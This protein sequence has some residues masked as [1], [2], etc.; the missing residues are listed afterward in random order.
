MNVLIDTQIILH[1]LFDKRRLSKKEK[2]ILL[3][4]D[5]EIFC[6]SISFFEIS[7]KYSIGK[8]KLKN[9]TP[10]EIPQL[11]INAGYVIEDVGYDSLSTFHK[12]PIATHKDPF[13]RIIIWEAIKKDYFLLTQDK[14]FEKYSKYGLELL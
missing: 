6:S 5:N 11:M 4:Q 7:L 3:N 12:L 2:D 9:V 8:L 1:V 13:D 10:E 14:Q